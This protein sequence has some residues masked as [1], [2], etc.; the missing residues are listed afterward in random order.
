MFII[1]LLLNYTDTIE[2]VIFD[3]NDGSTLQIA[4]ETLSAQADLLKGNCF[5]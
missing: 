1:K 4:C 5:S 3:F 2:G